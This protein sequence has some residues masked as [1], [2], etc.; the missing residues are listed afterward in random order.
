MPNKN[1]KVYD[2]VIDDIKNKIKSGEIKKG[3]RLPSERELSESL[4]VSRTSIREAI[5]A[6]EVIGLVESRRGAGNYIKTN[7]EDSLFEPLS[8]MFMLQESSPRE[9]FDVRES[10]ELQCARLSAK[11]IQ[12]NE[13]ALLAA[14]LDR[15]YLAES[16]EESLELDIKFHYIVAKASRNVLLINVLEVISQLMDEFIKKFRMQILHVGNTK[17]SLLEIHENL[18]RA[19]KSRDE[20]KVYNAMKE[21]FNLIRKAYDYDE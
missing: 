4:G 19:L 18:F 13:L 16:E 3:D 21:H 10:L 7:F 5:R 6:L 11:N 12:D 20:A 8:V 15:M 17:E 2:Q 14:I 1:P 9:M